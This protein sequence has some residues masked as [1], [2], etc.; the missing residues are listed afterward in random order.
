M[1]AKYTISICIWWFSLPNVQ[2]PLYK[3]SAQ[4]LIEQ[5]SITSKDDCHLP[6]NKENVFDTT[7]IQYYECMQLLE[8]QMGND[9]LGNYNT[10]LLKYFYPNFSNRDSMRQL[11][12]SSKTEINNIILDA[13]NNYSN[14]IKARIDAASVQLYAAKLLGIIQGLSENGTPYCSIKKAIV[15]IEKNIQK[16]KR[17]NAAERKIILQACSIARY[18]LY[19]WQRK[20]DITNEPVGK[21]KLFRYQAIC[22]GTVATALVEKHN[23]SSIASC[24]NSALAS[25]MLY[26][27]TEPY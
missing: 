12:K 25:A 15:A 20:I 21:F 11:I 19:Y 16:D 17:V 5:Q 10:M 9:L 18:S 23:D 2:M 24:I 4:A 22:L 13:S 26:E 8:K 7:G 3:Q 1:P 6:A 14:I 27:S